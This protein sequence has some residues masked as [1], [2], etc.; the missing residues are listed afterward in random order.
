MTEP[1]VAQLDNLLDRAGIHRLTQTEIAAVRAGVLGLRRDI[2]TVRDASE[3]YHRMHEEARDALEAHGG[4]GD[5]WPDIVAPILT[6]IAAGERDA[7]TVQRV[8]ELHRRITVYLAAEYCACTDDNPHHEEVHVGEYVCLDSPI[9]DVCAHCTV[10]ECD[11][12]DSLNER[13]VNWPCPTAVELVA[14]PEPAAPVPPDRQAHDPRWGINPATGC[15]LHRHETCAETWCTC[16]CHRGEPEAPDD[17]PG[18]LHA[19]LAHPDWEYETTEGQRKA[20]VDQDVPPEGDGWER[21][22]DHGRGGWNRFDYTEEA[23]WRRL[24]PASGAS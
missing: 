4:H 15:G 20:F 5:C 24:R 1:P 10:P 9:G 3:W 16:G 17:H 14:E 7:A 12:A 2:T 18:W 6:M 8:R 19:D 13:N 21:N 11:E 23:Y 22:V